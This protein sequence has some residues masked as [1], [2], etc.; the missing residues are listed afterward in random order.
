MAEAPVVEEM[1]WLGGA[2]V[3][4]GDPIVDASRIRHVVVLAVGGQVYA[5]ADRDGGH[6]S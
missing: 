6:L 5:C 2:A 1:E 4:G 3:D